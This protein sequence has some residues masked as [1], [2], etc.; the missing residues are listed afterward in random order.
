MAIAE[1][2]KLSKRKN[3]TKQPISSGTQFSVD[4]KSGTSF[5]S[6]TLLLNNSGKPDYNYVSFEGWYY[7]IS[8]IISVH[9]DLWEI[10]CNVDCLATGKAA[11]LNTHAYVVYDS[12][13]NTEIPDNR[14]P[15]K[16]SKSVQASSTACPLDYQSGG[17]Y[18]LSIT[19]SNDSTGIYKLDAATLADL[20]DDVSDIKDDF[21]PPTTPPDPTDPIYSGVDG[22]IRYLGDTFQFM[23]DRIKTAIS[24]FFGSG[25]IPEN[26]RE[27]K[28]IPFDVGTSAN[29]T[30]ICLGTYQTQTTL[31]KLNT[32]TVV[33]SA[34]VSIPWQAS[35]YRRRS[36]YTD[37]YLYMPYIGMVRLSSENLVGQS[38]LSIDYAVSVRDGSIIVTVQAGSQVVGQYSGNVAVSVP[39]GISNISMPKVATSLITG[40]ISAAKGNIGNVGFSAIQF[41]DAVTPNFSCIG[42]LDGLAGIATPQNIVCYTVFHDTVVAPNTDLATIGSPTMAPKALSALTGF[43][44]CMD[45]HVEAD[46]PDIILSEIDSYL[47]SGFFI[48]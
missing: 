1:F 31:Y 35:D 4:L 10:H 19:G 12:V 2:Y 7:F 15:M 28:Y 5:I 6:P 33:R 26:I 18:I 25:N 34:S 45:A 17:T 24:N 37:V 39:I 29:P 36:P 27:C 23:G 3:S 40:A 43:C 8:D 20:I 38:S 9:N 47:N 48:E 21:F 30:Q 44:Q 32:D 11:I 22:K 14:I 41:A 42:G 16:T 46:L 13:S